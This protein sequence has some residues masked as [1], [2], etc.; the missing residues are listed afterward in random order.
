MLWVGTYAAKGG[1]GLHPIQRSDAAL[2]VGEPE[3][4]IVNASFGVWSDAARTAYFVD[5]REEGRITAWRRDSGRWRSIGAESTGG[6][7][8]CYV[9]LSPD[10]R[11][12]A[13]AN[14]GD[15][16]VALIGLDPESGRLGQITDIVRHTGRGKDP[17]RQE[18]PHAHCAVFT[19]DGRELYHVDLGQDR[20]FAY[21][22]AS[23]RI[24]RQAIALVLPG[25]AGPRHIALHPDRQHALLLCE[26]SGEL[27]L[28]RRE[29]EG[30]RVIHALPGAPEGGGADNL[31]GHL[32]IAADGSIL[33]TN[34]G[35]DSLAEFAISGGRLMRRGWR[36]TGGASPRHFHLD[37]VHA[38]VAHEESGS[39]SLL[40]RP[41]AEGDAGPCATAAVPGAAF[42][43]DFPELNG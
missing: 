5:E 37:G 14:Y 20:V 25:G 7:L 29:S 22:I 35:H 3:P 19:E 6:A 13:V 33:V 27:L 21:A 31:G 8:P 42:V 16:S 2:R 10:R 24:E 12:V 28:L 11:S 1:A 4:G 15:G 23:G 43:I 34:R 18:G 30:L 26:L 40:A 17:E 9:S 41:S 39:V 38:L 32:S 36:H